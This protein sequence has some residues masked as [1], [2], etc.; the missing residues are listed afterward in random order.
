VELSAAWPR[1]LIAVAGFAPFFAVFLRRGMGEMA[2]ERAQAE[3]VAVGAEP[4]DDADGGAGGERAVAE[5]LARGG[6]RQMDL[7]DRDSGAGDR[8]AQRHARVGQSTG[9]EQ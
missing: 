5:G 6:V 4:L 3:Q 9:I 2:G 1:D 8:V 7:D